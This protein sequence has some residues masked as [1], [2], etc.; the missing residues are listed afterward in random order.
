MGE[1]VVA[2]LDPSMWPGLC[3]VFGEGGDPKSCWC[4][5]WRFSNSEAAG[6]STADRRAW[7]EQAAYDATNGE[8]AIAPGLV[9]H[10]DGQVLG[11]VSLAPRAAYGRLARSRTIPMIDG[12]NVWSVVCFVIG[13]AARGRRLSATLLSAAVDFAA[14]NGA[15]MLEAYPASVPH[16]S[17]IPAAAA[18]TGVESLFLAAGFTRIA[19][20]SSSAAGHPRVIVRRSLTDGGPVAGPSR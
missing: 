14:E 11:W 5:F 8:P 20:T 9:A 1:V 12:D 15:E 2:A 18:Y 7:L 17:R 6:L 3:D 4:T 19:E 16:G 10:E 13:R